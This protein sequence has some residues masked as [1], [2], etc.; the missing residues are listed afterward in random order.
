[1]Y[2][3][4]GQ[5][6]AEERYKTYDVLLCHFQAGK[7]L[8]KDQLTRMTAGQRDALLAAQPLYLSYWEGFRAS[9]S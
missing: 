5:V 1:M 4:T 3:G 6:P 8:Y 9:V 2:N 7:S